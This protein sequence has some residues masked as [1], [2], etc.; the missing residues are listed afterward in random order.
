MTASVPATLRRLRRQAGLSLKD[1]AALLDVH[2]TTVSSWERGRSEPPLERLRTLARLYGVDMAALLAGSPEVDSLR[3]FR[4]VSPLAG[5]RLLTHLEELRLA[6]CL[7]RVL[8][9]AGG[10]QKLARTTGIP[11]GRLLD[12]ASGVG[13]PRPAEVAVLVRELG[14]PGADTLETEGER[15]A[16]E[17]LP[18]ALAAAIQHLLDR[19]R[20][21]LAGNPGRQ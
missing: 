10:P 11:G 14:T 6:I 20:A 21:Y 13:I 2:F 1:V 8:A 4:P 17:D 18:P 16:G 9:E 7:G 3:G 15:N 12:L 5:E 19:L